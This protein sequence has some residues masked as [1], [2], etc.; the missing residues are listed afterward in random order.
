MFPREHVRFAL[1]QESFLEIRNFIIIF[2]KSQKIN[3]Q[4]YGTRKTVAIG[5]IIVVLSDRAWDF[6][7]YISNFNVTN[8]SKRKQLF[9]HY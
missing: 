5:T 1:A 3:S 8:L 4:L 7:F 2:R 6:F 9:L